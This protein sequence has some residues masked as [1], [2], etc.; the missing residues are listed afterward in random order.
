M[1]ELSMALKGTIL[2]PGWMDSFMLMLNVYTLT[3]ISKSIS[4][5]FR[6]KEH[7]IRNVFEIILRL[8]VL[9]LLVG[10]TVNVFDCYHDTTYDFVFNLSIMHSKTVVF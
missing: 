9:V 1:S 7:K 10:L 6:F 8:H 4:T 3:I 2:Q 5:L